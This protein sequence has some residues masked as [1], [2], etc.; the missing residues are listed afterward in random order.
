MPKVDPGGLGHLGGM[1]GKFL[2][3]VG[4]PLERTRPKYA[5]LWRIVANCSLFCKLSDNKKG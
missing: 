3:L 5:G 1:Q 2:G 4:L